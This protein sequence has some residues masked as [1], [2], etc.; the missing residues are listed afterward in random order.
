MNYLRG[1][2]SFCLVGCGR[3][4]KRHSD[5]LGSGEIKGA[6]LIG[7]CDKNI[8]KAQTIAKKFRVPSFEDYEAMMKDLRPDFVVVLTE[9]GNHAKDVINLS[10]FQTNIIVEKPMSLKVSDAEDMI[11]AVKINQSRLFVVKQN[12][13][14]LPVKKIKELLDEGKFGKLILGTVR[15]RWKRDHNYYDQDSWRGTWK[16]DGGVL[17]NQ[18]SHHIDL[19]QWLFGDVESVVGNSSRSLVDIEAE[20]TGT[21]LVTFKSGAIGVI[22]ATNASRPSDLEGSISILGEKGSA[23]IGGF[24]VNRLLH[25]KFNDFELSETEL[26]QFSE[27]PPDVYG[28]GHR[29][30]YNDIVA[31]ADNSF[32]NSMVSGDEGIKSVKL[33]NAIYKSI[34]EKRIVMLHEEDLWSKLGF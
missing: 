21:A 25:C 13:L 5:L 4:A 28:F 11:E 10:K 1:M 30:F 23:V 15:V 16:Y 31:S 19:L 8:E 27:N 6:K 32:R 34:E 9:S 33:I 18:A 3:I 24:S 22:E 2:Y 14:N 7:V 20:D 12:R 26:N 29:A 17:T